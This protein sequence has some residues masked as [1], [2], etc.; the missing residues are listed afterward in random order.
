MRANIMIIGAAVGNMIA[1]IMAI[2]RAIQS[3]A[4][5]PMVRLMSSSI[6]AACQMRSAQAAAARTSSEPRI[7]FRSRGRG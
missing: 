5:M 4:P 2:Q 7:R 1:T 3:G 6:T